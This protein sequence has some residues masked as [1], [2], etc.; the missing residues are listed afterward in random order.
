M[1]RSHNQH[2]VLRP[3]FATLPRAVV[4]RPSL[5]G[6][7]RPGI[8][9]ALKQIGVPDKQIRMRVGQLWQWIYQKGVVDFDEMTNLSK[10]FRQQLADAF[11]LD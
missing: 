1:L 10:E 2:S 3:D 9:E 11:S 6:L 8:S 4:G 7:T 5:V